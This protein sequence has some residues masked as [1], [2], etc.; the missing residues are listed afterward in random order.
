MELR[1]DQIPIAIGLHKPGLFWWD[2]N[3]ATEGNRWEK[4]MKYLAFLFVLCVTWDEAAYVMPWTDCPN[5]AVMRY[6]TRYL[7]G[8]HNRQFND[9]GAALEYFVGGQG[10]SGGFENFRVEEKPCAN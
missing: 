9:A 3:L 5:C 10:K 8:T 4:T 6:P 7:L 1:I 2:F